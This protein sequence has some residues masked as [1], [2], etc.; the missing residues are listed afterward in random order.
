MSEHGEEKLTLSSQ[1]GGL[2]AEVAVGVAT[3]SATPHPIRNASVA[4]KVIVFRVIIISLV[5]TLVLHAK[6]AARIGSGGACILIRI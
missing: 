1:P 3:P 5:S 6:R 4:K 2:D